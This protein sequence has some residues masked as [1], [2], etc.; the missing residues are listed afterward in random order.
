MHAIPVRDRFVVF[1]DPP[2][3]FESPPMRLGKE[4]VQAVDPLGNAWCRAFHK[5]EVETIE[6]CCRD[7][8]GIPVGL[9]HR[10]QY[11]HK[12]RA[13]TRGKNRVRVDPPE[14]IRTRTVGSMVHYSGSI[15]RLE[16]MPDGTLVPVLRTAELM[17][18][19]P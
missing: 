14:L 7:R 1:L 11:F 16:L 15:T 12:W 10:F 3:A 13:M 8:V 2:F 17:P 9:R 5:W 19:R 4:C 18:V 6:R